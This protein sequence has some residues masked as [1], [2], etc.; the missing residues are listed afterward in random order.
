MILLI[1]PN[2]EGL[3]V[4]VPVVERE[5]LL[6]YTVLMSYLSHAFSPRSGQTQCSTQ[7]G[8]SKAFFCRRSLAVVF[9]RVVCK[10]ALCSQGLVI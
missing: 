10:A 7:G 8:V 2:Q 4:V 9:L 3:L 6:S 1:D 5:V